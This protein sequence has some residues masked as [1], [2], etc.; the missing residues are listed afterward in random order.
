M[1][2]CKRIINIFILLLLFGL[3]F[4]RLSFADSSAHYNPE[5]IVNG[6]QSVEVTLETGRNETIDY[7]LYIPEKTGMSKLSIT[8][9]YK[10][11]SDYVSVAVLHDKDLNELPT[12]FYTNKSDQYYYVEKGRHYYIGIHHINRSSPIYATFKT[13]I[14]EE[15]KKPTTITGEGSVKIHLSYTA[16]D[17]RDVVI[18][19]EP[20]KN[21]DIILSSTPIKGGGFDF[22]VAELYEN[23]RKLIADDGVYHVVK[24]GNYHIRYRYLTLEENRDVSIIV[25]E[26]NSSQQ[27]IESI[28]LKDVNYFDVKNVGKKYISALVDCTTGNSSNSYQAKI[29]LLNVDPAS[30]K[31]N[32]CPCFNGNCF[33][34]DNKTVTDYYIYADNNCFSGKQSSDYDGVYAI[35]CA[36]IP[37]NGEYEGEAVAYS[38]V[39][40]KRIHFTGNGIELADVDG[41]VETISNKSLDELDDWIAYNNTYDSDIS[42]HIFSN[43]NVIKSATCT[44]KGQSKRVCELC[45][46]CET[47]DVSP[48]GHKWD[49]VTG[50]CKVCNAVNPN[51][52]KNGDL[53]TVKILK[54]KASKKSAII[55]WKKIS[56]ANQRKIAKI[57]IQYSLDKSFET[58]VKTVYAKKSSKSKKISKLKSK[59]T[60]YVRIRAYKKAGGVINVS[61]WSLTKSVKVK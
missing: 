19:Y 49:S 23:N 61:R 38:N 56:K 48:T 18:K 3:F 36:L 8:I 46:F 58:G 35:Q 31:Y 32:K 60:Y 24:G 25:N 37:G 11:S 2:Y 5:I 51:A 30:S 22:G 42:G 41:F 13:S 59:K 52:V 16:L 17:A 55:K 1:Q 45:N 26:G 10:I 15:G 54:A 43:W 28:T 53:P 4:V 12:A 40:Y 50:H 6:S 14:V 44:E 29:M 20:T 9:D 57:E 33:F 27:S 34:L 39:L 7:Y 21:T 47:K